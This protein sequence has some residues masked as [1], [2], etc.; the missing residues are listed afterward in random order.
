MGNA[1]DTA[2]GGREDGGRLL[3]NKLPSRPVVQWGNCD[4][5]GT[6]THV[7]TH[8]PSLPLSSSMAIS[9]PLLSTCFT[10]LFRR[11]LCMA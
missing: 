2:A 9:S 3:G 8:S 4:G 11:F 1:A 6:T 10:F 5:V 7:A